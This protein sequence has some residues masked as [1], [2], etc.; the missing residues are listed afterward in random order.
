[1]I[2]TNDIAFPTTFS[3]TYPSNSSTK[4]DSP[5]TARVHESASYEETHRETTNDD[6]NA[7]FKFERR[8][9]RNGLVLD[10]LSI[11]VLRLRMDPLYGI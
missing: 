9:D 6:P 5:H 4:H 3:Q 1:M 8:D 10:Q 11:R 2:G 7:G